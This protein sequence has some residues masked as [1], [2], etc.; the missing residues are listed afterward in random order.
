MLEKLGTDVIWSILIVGI[1]VMWL[2][3]CLLLGYYALKVKKKVALTLVILVLFLSG[4][5][6]KFTGYDLMLKVH[7]AK[8]FDIQSVVKVSGDELKIGSLPDNY[9]YKDNSF[10]KS[11]EQVFKVVIDDNLG[12]V[13]LSNKDTGKSVELSKE[14]ATWVRVE[15]LKQ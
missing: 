8:L 14:D 1:V 9:R 10:D 11:R 15:Q 5:L 4:L 3:L 13:Y 2:G 12:K 6:V 7:D